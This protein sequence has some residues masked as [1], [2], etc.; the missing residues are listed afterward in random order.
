MVIQLTTHCEGRYSETGSH[1]AISIIVAA[2]ERE[3]VIGFSLGES[4][5]RIG[6]PVRRRNSSH[7]FVAADPLAA[8][9]GH[10]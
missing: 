4:H 8:S 9:G 1:D 2:P 7:D 10:L 3:D 6:R 5:H